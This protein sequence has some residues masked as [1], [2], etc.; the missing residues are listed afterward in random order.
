[1]LGAGVLVLEIFATR[2]ILILVKLYV[3]GTR[4]K[5]GPITRV[6]LSLAKQGLISINI[7]LNRKSSYA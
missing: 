1:M 2:K 4:P 5:S 6:H 3:L 7:S